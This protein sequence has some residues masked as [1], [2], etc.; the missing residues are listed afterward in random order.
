MKTWRLTTS[1]LLPLPIEKVFPFFADAANLQRLTPGFL[2]F[3]FLTPLPVPMA[4]GTRIDYRIRLHGVP[5]RWQ[6]RIAAWDPPHRFVDEQVRGP[7]RLWRHEHRFEA[8]GGE[9]RMTDTVDYAVPG[10]FLA[11]LIERAF[12][13]KDLERI[14]QFRSRALAEVLLGAATEPPPIGFARVA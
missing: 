9:T 1:T 13:R 2:Q 8:E 11:G 3:R 10:A 4:V 14:F 12:V 7:F 5:I 6:T